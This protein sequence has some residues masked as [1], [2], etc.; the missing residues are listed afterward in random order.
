MNT[1]STTRPLAPRYILGVLAAAVLLIAFGFASISYAQ[2]LT[3]QLQMGMSG[4]DVTALQTFLAQ[5]PSIYPQGLVTGYFG[6]LTKAAV[7]NYQ[8]RNGI[9]TVGRVGP[10]TMQHMNARMGGGMSGDITAP[11]ISNVLI[12]STSNGATIHWN[13]NESSAGIVYYGTS[14]PTMTDTPTDATISGMVAMTS[15]S[16]QNSQNVSLTGLNAN[17]TYYYVI[18]VKDQSGNVQLTWPTTF[19]TIN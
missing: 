4:A 5:D 11:T 15:F 14:Y 16:Q 12:S 17:T 2:T 13:T 9:S 1:L 7:S 18:Y 6:N 10:V 8:S 19:K 3:R